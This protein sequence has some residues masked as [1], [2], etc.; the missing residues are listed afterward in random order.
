MHMRS[1]GSLVSESTLKSNPFDLYVSAALSQFTHT[2]QTKTYY[3][4]SHVIQFIQKSTCPQNPPRLCQCEH[5]AS[6]WRKRRDIQCHLS[7]LL[8]GRR[9]MEE[10]QYLWPKQ[11]SGPEPD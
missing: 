9:H 11:P 4:K 2:T 1:C 6:R 3:E 5:L 8:Q 10:F 7:A